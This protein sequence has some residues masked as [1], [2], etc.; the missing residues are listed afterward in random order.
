MAHHH[1]VS[2]A[3]ACDRQERLLHCINPA[4]STRYRGCVSLCCCMHACWPGPVWLSC[5]TQGALV[6]LSSPGQFNIMSIMQ[7]LCRHATTKR[8]V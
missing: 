3:N 1:L 6:F 8:H 2:H 7:A 4:S 5:S